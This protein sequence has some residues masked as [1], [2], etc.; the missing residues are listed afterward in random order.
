MQADF[1]S[2][3]SFG[4]G[5]TT[6]AAKGL[7]IWFVGGSYELSDVTLADQAAEVVTPANNMISLI[8]IIG[9]AS[10]IVIFIKGARGQLIYGAIVLN[11]V[12]LLTSPMIYAI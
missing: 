6:L 1:V 9:L 10:A 2:K 5:L 7:L 12:A 3:F 11:G 4:L 8:A